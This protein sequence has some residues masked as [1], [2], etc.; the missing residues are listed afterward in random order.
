MDKGLSPRG[1]GNLRRHPS[2]RLPC[3]VG[4][5]SPRG[6][7]NLDVI[8]ASSE[9]RQLGS[10]P[11][12]AGEL[13]GQYHQADYPRRNRHFVLVQSRFGVYPRVGG[14]TC[15]VRFEPLDTIVGSIPAWAGEPP[16]RGTLETTAAFAGS[17]PAWAGEPDITTELSGPSVLRTGLS[18]R[19]RG[20]PTPYSTQKHWAIPGNP[21][22]ARSPRV[23]PRVG[24]GTNNHVPRI[25]RSRGLSPRGRGN[26]EATL[27]YNGFRNSGS[28]PAW[29]GEPV[30]QK[31]AARPDM[32]GSIP[33]WAGEP[34]EVNQVPS[35]LYGSIPAWAGE[36]EGNQRAYLAQEVYPRV[37][38]G[39][40]IEPEHLRIAVLGLSPRG[41]GNRRRIGEG[42][43]H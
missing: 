7:G 16:R 29:A 42:Y 5:L 32:P 31:S 17:I 4:G 39:T 18:P 40:P 41:R 43:T 22:F 3:P 11:A 8:L 15:G 14:G 10:I 27:W 1:R 35:A 2:V 13:P 30:S 6:R 12:W 26:L 20:N 36:P 19:G 34:H 33:A 25:G 38:G 9:L 24:G 37:G 21:V 28:I 23:Y